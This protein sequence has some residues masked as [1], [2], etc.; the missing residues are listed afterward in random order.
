MQMLRN[1]ATMVIVTEYQQNE[2]KN[3][4]TGIVT[5]E[6]LLEEV[7]GEIYDEKDRVKM[8]GDEKEPSKEEKSG[9]NTKQGK[10]RAS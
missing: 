2:L 6:D 7:V 4:P 1:N 9:N 5:L 8:T 3:V 10:R